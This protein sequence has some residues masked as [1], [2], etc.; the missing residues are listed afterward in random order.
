M[1]KQSKKQQKKQT[2]RKASQKMI[3]AKRAARK[4]ADMMAALPD[5][6]Q[7]CR[8]EGARRK[9]ERSAAARHTGRPRSSLLRD[10]A[11]NKNE[12]SAE[13][14][15]H[16][17][18]RGF[19]FVTPDGGGEDIF[20]PAVAVHGATDGD[21]VRVR[22]HSFTS[23][24]DGKEEEKTEGEVTRILS[25]ASRYLI[26]TL[27]TGVSGFG[28]NR[29]TYAYVRADNPR[30]GQ[31]V[32]LSDSGE[33]ADG[34]KVEVLLSDDRARGLHGRISRVF[35]P[36]VDRG[37]NYEAILSAL[38]VRVEFPEAVEREAV[39][40]AALPLSE[41][42][43]RVRLENEAILTIDGAGA[44]DL[45]DAVSLRRLPKGG[46]LLGVHIADVSEYVTAGSETDK[47]AIR[48][49]TSLYFADRV[50]PML[51]KALS[52]GACSLNAGEDKYALS[53]FLTLSAEGEI[54]KTEVRRT[55]IRSRVR[56]VYEEVNDL[57]ERGK[58]SEYAGKYRAVAPA[59]G[60][61]RE[62]YGILA[63]RAEARGAM[64]FDRPEPI[65]ILDEAGDVQDIF[66]RERGEAERM[67]E[68]FM[69]T[70]NEGV[71]TLCRDRGIPCVYRV[72][73]KPEAGKLQEFLLYAHNLGLKTP[74]KAQE[75][76]D[77]RDFAGLL[78]EAKEKGISRA[79][80]YSLLRAMAKAKYSEKCL[81]HF[82]LG[83]ANYCHFTSPIRRL[84]D[85]ATHRM[86]KAVLLDGEETKRY[87]GYA[88]RAAEAASD[89]ELRALEAEREIEAL[90]KTAYMKAHEGEEFDAVVSGCAAFGLFAELPNTCEGMIP[91]EDFEDDVYF[92]EGTYTLRAGEA[93][94]T[95]GTPLRVRVEEADISRRRVRFSVVG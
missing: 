1:K 60:R 55:L 89:C 86:L 56:G 16:G 8:T 29:R 52:N 37:A 12:K 80:S 69:L 22:Y 25:F 84:S 3:A 49:G 74:A 76:I 85:L 9:F 4:R 23:R 82:G 34:D 17:T 43:G 46:W 6:V 28:R 87:K 62:L 70:A 59:L 67:I 57:F 10:K 42:N 14:I 77:G 24:R 64:D 94:Y 91:V 88:V 95:V 18:A 35:G 81:G 79:V 30:I 27:Y 71:A 83:I 21:T 19:G 44:K 73:E 31:D 48:R 7:D 61:M 92:N 32:W 33:G 15:F 72:H 68:Q 39:E 50:V 41:G 78:T 66:C 36:A 58:E 20:I 2:M 75:D 63:A 51:P 5:G 26:G 93:V 47:E 54:Q 40:R 45:D 53:A 11:S 13:G 38:D 90:Y 65:L